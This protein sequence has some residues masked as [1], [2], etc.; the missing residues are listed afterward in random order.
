MVSALLFIGKCKLK[1]QYYIKL[2][3]GVNTVN[4]TRSKLTERQISTQVQG[5][6][7]MRLTEKGPTL[8]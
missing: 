5:V 6:V 4:L 7:Y 1:L 3:V 2:P 8:M